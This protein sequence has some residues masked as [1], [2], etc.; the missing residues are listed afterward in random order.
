[1]SKNDV[2]INIKNDLSTCLEFNNTLS[3]VS[4]RK[5]YNLKVLH[6]N[7]H[8]LNAKLDGFCDL[9]NCLD[10]NFDVIVLT[11]IWGTNVSFFRNLLPS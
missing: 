8:S 2:F 7:I 1:M 4:G 3:K 6:L 10:V 11:E 5:F 9:I